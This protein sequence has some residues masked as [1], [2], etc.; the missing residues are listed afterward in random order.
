MIIGPYLNPIPKRS[1]N[2]TQPPHSPLF[3][4]FFG[5]N[6]HDTVVNLASGP[7]RLTGRYRPADLKSNLDDTCK[8]TY[9]KRRRDEAPV[10][11]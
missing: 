1:M 9:T 11:S 3:L 5:A 2:S 7:T 8:N 6:L 4:L 10:L